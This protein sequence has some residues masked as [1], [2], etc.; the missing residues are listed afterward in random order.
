MKIELDKKTGNT[1]NL[2]VNF[3]AQQVNNI[4]LQVNIRRLSEQ[5]HMAVIY[6]TIVKSQK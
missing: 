4:L 3:N 2:S 6:F 1:K 5:I